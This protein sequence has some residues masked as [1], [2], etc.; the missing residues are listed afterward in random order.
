PSTRPLRWDRKTK[1]ASQ[2]G[3]GSAPASGSDGC[4]NVSLPVVSCEDNKQNGPSHLQSKDQRD[5]GNRPMPFPPLP[6]TCC[7]SG[8][9]NCVW[10][11][12]AEELMK[13]YPDGGEKALEMIEEHIEDE[14]LKAFLKM[15]IRLRMQDNI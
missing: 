2:E 4:G 1:V 11:T 15:E 12:Y 14:T 9:Q 3:I 5:W 10:V 8:C 7:M 6:T 13:N